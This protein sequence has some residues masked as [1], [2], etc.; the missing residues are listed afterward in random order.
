MLSPTDAAV[1]LFLRRSLIVELATRSPKGR[2]FLTPLWF[3]S[4]GGALY[5]TTGPQT[6]AGKNIAQHP[7]VALLFNGERMSRCT[8][9]LRLRGVATCHVGLPSWPVLVRAAA[10]YYVSPQALRVELRNASH[11]W[12]RNLY[13]GQLKGGVG[14][15]RVVATA[16]EFIPRP[17]GASSPPPNRSSRSLSEIGVRP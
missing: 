12:L 16:A 17:D 9:L 7:Q 6:W 5:I 1:R 2:P 13:Y 14:Y 10:K 11:W 8:Q 3:V 4:H 15:I